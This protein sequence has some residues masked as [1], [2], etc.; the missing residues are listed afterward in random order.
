MNINRDDVSSI[1]TNELLSLEYTLCLFAQKLLVLYAYFRIE[2]N[3]K[4]RKVASLFEPTDFGL[5]NKSR[6]EIHDAN[7]HLNLI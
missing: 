5:I 3:R 1:L 4:K 2:V 7:F 6:V